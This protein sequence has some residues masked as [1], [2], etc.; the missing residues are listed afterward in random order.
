M[1]ENIQGY[2]VRCGHDR[3]YVPDGLPE[4]TSTRPGSQQRLAVLRERIDR[5]Q[6]LFHEFDKRLVA[7]EDDLE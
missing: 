5:G 2:L 6:E 3:D 4:P 7:W 1:R